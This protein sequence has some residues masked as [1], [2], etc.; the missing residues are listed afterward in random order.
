M[1]WSVTAQFSDVSGCRVA[2]EEPETSNALVDPYPTKPADGKIKLLRS[3][4]MGFGDCRHIKE[5]VQL[6]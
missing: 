4:S 6:L 5:G 2:H 1:S 3:R